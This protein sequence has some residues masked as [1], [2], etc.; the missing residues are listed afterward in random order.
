MTKTT[1]AVADGV[2]WVNGARVPESREVKLSKAEAR[3]DLE[4]GRITPQ[5]EEAADAGDVADDAAPADGPVVV[6][7]ITEVEAEAPRTGSRKLKA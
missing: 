1:Y 2:D 3:F 5:G 7:T 6:E 4:Q